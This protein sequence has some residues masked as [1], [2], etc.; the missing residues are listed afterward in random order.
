MAYGPSGTPLAARTP[1]VQVVAG[2][3][4][5]VP[6]LGMTEGDW[7]IA[8]VI[9][10]VVGASWTVSLSLPANA[11]TVERLAPLDSSF[12]AVCCAALQKP[13]VYVCVDPEGVPVAYVPLPI[14]AM[15]VQPLADGTLLLHPDFGGVMARV[16]W[17][18]RPL[19][20]W[21]LGDLSGFRYRHDRWDGHDAVSIDVGTWAGAY[22]A[23][24]ATRDGERL[25]SGV[26]VFDPSTQQVLWDWTGHGVLGDGVSID[27]DALPYAR[28]RTDG[29]G[30]PDD[31]MHANALVHRSSDLG[32]Q[33]WMSLRHQDW[34]IRIDPD[35][36]AVVARFGAEG[37]VALVDDVGADSPEPAEPEQWSYHQHAPEFVVDDQGQLQL[38]VVDNGNTRP[39]G[40]YSRLV[41]FELDESAQRASVSWAYGGPPEAPST[42]FLPTAGDIDAGSTGV[43][44]S[45]HDPD[46]GWVSDIGWD[47]ALRG[48][49]RFVGHGEL[50][51]TESYPSLYTTGAPRSLD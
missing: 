20:A 22:A 9:D 8:P 5:E 50:Y 39:G 34:V 6:V 1:A 33:V 7:S 46:D 30:D 38:F 27:P 15:V 12:G 40:A 26:V 47:G 32:E 31:W 35:T 3:A 41:R 24:T 45:H 29:D 43:R 17:L 25:A 19:G 18:G 36:D 37:D 42:F 10:D 11:P 21:R 23:L 51:R 48:Q 44:F 13:D 2:A 16:D 4:V 14:P 49:V 28:V